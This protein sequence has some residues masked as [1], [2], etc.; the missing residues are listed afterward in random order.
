MFTVCCL[1]FA[2]P[3][4]CFNCVRVLR[5]LFCKDTCKCSLNVLVFLREMSLWSGET[6]G[7]SGEV[8]AANK[9]RGYLMGTKDYGS[10]A[11]D[12]CTL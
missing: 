9:A 12:Y 2:N 8:T 4:V 1:P 7:N 10:D 6:Q 5:T 3:K 11:A